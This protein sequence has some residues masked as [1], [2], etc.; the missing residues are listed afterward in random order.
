MMARKVFFKGL[1][2]LFVFILISTAYA[3]AA[4]GDIFSAAAKGDTVKLNELIKGTPG[5]I[6]EKG[7]GGRTALHYACEKDRTDAISLLILK[8]ADI[9]AKDDTGKTPLHY[10]A[11]EGRRD[12]A[13]LL[14]E[15]EQR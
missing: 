13:I 8:G 9:N 12:A 4:S 10:A 3:Q 14:L 7:D 11:S 15:K 2:Y 6:N 1:S 5:L